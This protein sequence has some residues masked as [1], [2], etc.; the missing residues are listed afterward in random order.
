MNL[1]KHQDWFNPHE[2]KAPIH[3]IGV[4]A[5]G[6]NVLN[7]LVRLGFDD[8][9]IYDFDEVNSHNITNQ[10]YTTEDLGRLKVD[11]IADYVKKINP[12]LKLT[13]YPKGWVPGTKLSGHLITALDS[14]EL[15]HKIFKENEM[16]FELISGTDMRIGLESAQMYFAD[17]TSSEEINKLIGSM[18]FKDNEVEQAVSACGTV[19]SVLPTIQVIVS[20]GVMNLL[21]F[22]KSK[23]YNTMS[24]IDSIQGIARSYK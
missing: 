14:I 8:I 12:S 22:I 9:H 21:N 15:R 3:L 20:L 17:F 4:G 19:L 10:L 24:I 1:N 2:N 16:N 6:S 18:D 11:A 7:Q 23:E 5:I 13:L